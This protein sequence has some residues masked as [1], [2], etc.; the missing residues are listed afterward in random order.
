MKS[1][2]VLRQNPL[3]QQVFPKNIVTTQIRHQ[4]FD[5]NHPT[6]V[7]NRFTGSEPSHSPQQQCNQTYTTRCFYHAG[8]L[9]Q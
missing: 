5:Y 3:D 1:D 6:Y 8:R 7:V 2:S 9:A 4:N